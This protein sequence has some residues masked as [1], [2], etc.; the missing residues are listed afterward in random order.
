MDL[1]QPRIKKKDYNIAPLTKVVCF[2]FI[3][4]SYVIANSQTPILDMMSYS[5]GIISGSFLAP[6]MLS[7]YASRISKTAA[8]TGMIGGFVTAMP[9]LAAKLFFPSVKLGSFGALADLGPQFACLAMIV[10]LVLCIVVTI[11]SPAKEQIE[12]KLAV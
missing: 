11:A 9:P 4:L 2:V 10:S 3:I 12:E 5:W 6:Y 8:W 7:L 1:I